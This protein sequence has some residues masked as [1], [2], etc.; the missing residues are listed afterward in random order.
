MGVINTE[1]YHRAT[2]ALEF[3]ARFCTEWERFLIF[4]G[5]FLG[6]CSKEPPLLQKYF[7]KSNFYSSIDFQRLESNTSSGKYAIRTVSTEKCKFTAFGETHGT[8]SSSR[9]ID[10]K[11]HRKTYV[12]LY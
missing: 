1:I 3:G 4:L 11:G 12:L 10:K 6:N 5:N 8:R 2:Q 9:C 7:V